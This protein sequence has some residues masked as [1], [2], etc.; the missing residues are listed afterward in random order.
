MYD[1]AVGESEA[2]PKKPDPTAA[3]RIMD[4][5]AIPENETI[6]IGDSSVDLD[7]ARNAGVDSAWVSWGLRKREEMQGC[8]ITNAFD[9]PADLQAFLLE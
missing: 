7:T 2:T 4:A 6:Y 5:F 3:R 9:S 8:E 1:Y